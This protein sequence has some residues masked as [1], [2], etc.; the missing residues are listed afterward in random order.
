[1]PGSVVILGGAVE[2]FFEYEIETI[3]EETVPDPQSEL[4]KRY[5]KFYKLQR[6]QKF[7]DVICNFIERRVNKGKRHEVSIDWRK[8]IDGAFPKSVASDP[9]WL[10][11][12]EEKAK[13]EKAA[14]LD[15]IA[16]SRFSVLIGPAGTGKTTLL[17]LF[18]E[19]PQIKNTGIL[20]LA[21]TSQRF[22]V[23]S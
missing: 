2:P 16:R 5:P 18:C 10:K 4:Q 12:K 11:K 13:T 9:E 6:L 20:R 21:S 7:K 23:V 14:A 22:S 1:M 8:I 3:A 17:N 15:E 19:Q